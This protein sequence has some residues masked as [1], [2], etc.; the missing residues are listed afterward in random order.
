[1]GEFR[2]VM[3]STGGKEISWE[4]TDNL[5]GTCGVCSTLLYE[6]LIAQNRQ[7]TIQGSNQ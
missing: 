1:M 7:V 6:V 5:D 2:V 3:Y 4:M